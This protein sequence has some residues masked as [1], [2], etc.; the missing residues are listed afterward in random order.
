M[1]APPPADRTPRIEHLRYPGPSLVARHPLAELV[2]FGR[3]QG[4]EVVLDPEDR[5]ISRMA[6]SIHRHGPAWLLRNA[7]SRATLHLHR[8]DGAFEQ[9]R[10]GDR[11][12]ELFSGDEIEIPTAGFPHRLRVFLPRRDPITDPGVVPE[13][14]T[15][16]LPGLVTRDDLR[17]DRNQWQLLAAL[18]IGWILPHRY[19]REPTDDDTIIRLITAPGEEVMSRKAVQLRIKRLRERIAEQIGEPLATR[20]DLCHWAESALVVTVRDV[21]QLPGLRR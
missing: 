20:W 15:E 2:R 19:A 16:N 18:M 6:G 3:S 10:P 7:S 8:V 17:L 12:R 4:C 11:P 9:L 13:E 21:E 14:P 1:H 5:S